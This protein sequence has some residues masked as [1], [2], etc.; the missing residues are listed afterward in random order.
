VRFLFQGRDDLVETLDIGGADA[1]D[2]DAF[3]SR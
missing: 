2:N 3:Q 1:M